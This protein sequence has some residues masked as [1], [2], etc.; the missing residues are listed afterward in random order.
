MCSHAAGP[1]R[2]LYFLFVREY[3]KKSC[4]VRGSLKFA[5]VPIWHGP[6]NIYKLCYILNYVTSYMHIHTLYHFSTLYICES[7][8]QLSPF[9]IRAYSQV[10]AVSRLILPLFLSPLPFRF[11][12]FFRLFLLAV[13]KISQLKC[14][15]IYLFTGDNK[16]WYGGDPA[17]RGLRLRGV[18]Q[19]ARSP[20]PHLP[21]GQGLSAL[22]THLSKITWS[23]QWA[24]E[25]SRR[26]GHL[27]A[28]A[29]RAGTHRLSSCWYKMLVKPHK[30]GS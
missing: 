15:S 11:S 27:M 20:A 17:V 29:R 7:I 9:F 3:F 8:L 10:A 16:P 30:S 28:A 19:R 26:G 4:Y 14:V 13:A 24:R 25:H 2:S 22:R 6:F 23:L 18:H 12:R 5:F 21:A 1:C